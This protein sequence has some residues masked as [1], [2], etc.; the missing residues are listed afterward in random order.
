VRHDLQ[1]VLGQLFDL[2][3][4][5]VEAHAHFAG[6]R[7]FGMQ[8]RLEAVVAIA[9]DAS[10]AVA[11]CVREFDSDGSRR[12]VL[13]ETPPPLSGP[14]PTTIAQRMAQVLNTIHCICAG[15]DE[16]DASIGDLLREIAC[17]VE[18]QALLLS[19]ES[20]RINA[21]SQ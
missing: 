16:A 14:L 9:R 4:Q 17:T 1:A 8:Q 21:R 19:S 10:G 11:D 15:L 2:H 18:K 13:I 12:L 7:F 20:R 6:T 5:A 3:V